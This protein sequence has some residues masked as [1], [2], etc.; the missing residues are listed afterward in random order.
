MCYKKNPED[1]FKKLT[2]FKIIFYEKIPYPPASV[3]PHDNHPFLS[4]YRK[5]DQCGESSTGGF[6]C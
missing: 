2:A 1:I 6:L 5:Y 3:F 4:V